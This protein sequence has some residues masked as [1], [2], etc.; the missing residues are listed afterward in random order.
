MVGKRYI[1]LKKWLVEE[2][3]RFR[4]KISYIVYLPKAIIDKGKT[5]YW[6][7]EYLGKKKPTAFVTQQRAPTK[8]KAIY[9]ENKLKLQYS[10]TIHIIY[11]TLISYRIDYGKKSTCA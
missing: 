7:E 2:C 5:Y 6:V 11:S 1:F 3:G 9:L 10:V 4:V 8:A